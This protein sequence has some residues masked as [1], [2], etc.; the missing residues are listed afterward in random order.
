MVGGEAD[1]C[2]RLEPIFLTLA[3]EDG[4]LRVGGNGAGHYVK[5]IHNGIEYGLMQAYAEGFELMHASDYGIDLAGRRVALD[6]GQRRP[7][8]A[9]RADGAGAWSRT[10]ELDGLEAYV[11]DSGEGRWTA[12]RSDRARGADAGADGGALHALP[13]ARRQSVLGAAARGA[14]ESVRRARGEESMIGEALHDRLAVDQ[15]SPIAPDPSTLVIFGGDGDLAHRKLLPALY[16]LH[17]DGL[18]PPRFAVVGAGRKPMSDDGVPRVR[19]RRR[20][21]VLA[22]PDR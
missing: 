7:I 12:A 2:R 8:V 13:V 5:M 21:E 1:V 14:P 3:P 19:E 20:D 11:E 15:A 4:Y 10:R 16:N 22:P 9:A 18:L 6:A 17:V